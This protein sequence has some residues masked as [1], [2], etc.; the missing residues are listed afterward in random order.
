MAIALN[1]TLTKIAS[2]TL[3][4]G[5]TTV[6]FTAIPATYTDLVVK[7]SISTASINCYARF[8]N[9]ASALYSLQTLRG[10]GTTA[11]NY[12][13]GASQTEIYFAGCPVTDT[14]SS[15]EFYITNYTAA[16]Q[17]SFFLN[18]VNE[19]NVAAAYMNQ[20]SGSWDSAAAITQIDIVCA[21]GMSQYSSATLY[22]VNP[23]KT[24][25][26]ATGG[27]IVVNDGTY[28]YHAFLA[29]GTFRPT[30]SLSCDVLTIAG[31]GAGGPN[32]HGAGGGAGGL[33]Y[34]TGQSLSAATNYTATV[35]AGGTS[36]ALNPTPG[37]NGTNSQF[38]SVTAAV[39]G[40]GGG[41]LNG[42]PANGGSGGGGMYNPAGLFGTGTAGQGNNGG[43]GAGGPSYGAGGGGGAGAVGTAGDAT[44][45]RGNGGIGVLTYSSWATATGTGDGGYYAGGG[46]GS[47]YVSGS[48][49]P[50][51]GGLG[52]GSN[53]STAT[54]TAAMVNTGGGGGGSERA[55]GT[56]YG[57]TGGSGIII[58]R[59]AMA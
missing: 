33:V 29:S 16:T 5:Q 35:G 40:G 46:G 32:L 55:S 54:A 11:D 13:T 4:T 56:G 41:T 44:N 18:T 6:S 31:G 27:D 30:V 57:G 8:N 36:T 20:L 25:A 7:F 37:G 24:Q 48:G 59:Y 2:V 50:G 39:G 28:W 42:T 53:G 26:L 47:S 22:G 17:K 1:N 3:G 49:S 52:G 51:I 12:V 21:A 34:V 43:I 38:G 45:G 9:S 19:A 10:S 15:S 58:I 23:V 14:F